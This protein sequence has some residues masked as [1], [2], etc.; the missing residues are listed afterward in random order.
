MYGYYNGMRGFGSSAAGQPS[1]T[2]PV[3]GPQQPM[4]TATIGV[5]AGP[6]PEESAALAKKVEEDFK[7][8]TGMD[9][10]QFLADGQTV[11]AWMKKRTARGFDCEVDGGL[12]LVPKTVADA[13]NRLFVSMLGDADIKVQLS[14]QSKTIFSAAQPGQGNKKI[15]IANEIRSGKAFLIGS[16]STPQAPQFALVS[17]PR[18]LASLAGSSGSFCIISAPSALLASA[19]KLASGATTASMT[20]SGKEVVLGIQFKSPAAQKLNRVGQVVVGTAAIYHGYKR[21]ESVGWAIGWGI[22]GSMFWPIAAPLM[23]AQGFGKPAKK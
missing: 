16:E 4:Q 3:L 7:R 22:L 11:D 17:T 5:P 15:N 19:K 1:S 21:N 2:G 23:I 20:G 13:L 14:D 6:T 18:A 8:E 12:K 10:Q 9:M